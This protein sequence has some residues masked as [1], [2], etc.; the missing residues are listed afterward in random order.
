M[1]PD[2]PSRA[3]VRGNIVDVRFARIIRKVTVL[4][5]AVVIAAAMVPAVAGVPGACNARKAADFGAAGDRYREAGR[6][7]DAAHWYLAATRFTRGCRTAGDS[8]LNARSLAQAGAALAQNGDY[9][10]ALELLHTA[11]SRLTSI[12]ALDPRAAVAAQSYAAVVQRMLSAING[13]AEASM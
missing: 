13:V 12:A 11:Q 6:F 4:S 7:V 10:G 5:A 9:L 8:L 1:S 3:I 2:A